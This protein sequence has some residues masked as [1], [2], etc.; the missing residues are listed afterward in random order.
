MLRRKNLTTDE[1]AQQLNSKTP[2]L[3]SLLRQQQPILQHNHWFDSLVE[4]DISRNKLTSL[5]TE[6]TSLS[7]L[8]TLNASSNLLTH[9]PPELY[10]LIHLQVLNLSQNQLHTIPDQLP[11]QLPYLVTLSVAGNSIDYLTPNVNRWIYLRHLQLGSVFGGNLLTQLPETICDMPCLEELELSF[12]QLRFLPDSM[13][14]P[15]LVNLNISR[16]Q[17]DSL[18]TSIGQC[19]ALKTLNVSKNHLTSLPATLVDLDSLELLDISENLLCIIPADILERMKMTLLITG[20]PL[21]RPGH[22]DASHASDD[23]Y[24][25][26]LKRMTTCALPMMS[27]S[28]GSPSSIN[29]QCGPQGNGCLSVAHTSP[30]IRST[31]SSH[32]IALAPTP[33]HTV[34]STPPPTSSSSLDNHHV[35]SRD[36]DTILD[37][38]LSILAQ[39]LNVQGSRSRKDQQ[40][41]TTP[42]DM[43]EDTTSTTSSDINQPMTPSLSTSSSSSTAH[44]TITPGT[45]IQDD[46][47]SRS[48]LMEAAEAVPYDED[49]VEAAI[50]DSTIPT[51]TNMLHSLRELATRVILQSDHVKV[52]FHL[53]PPHLAHDLS[54]RHQRRRC[55]KCQL[56]FVNEWLTSVQVKSYGGHPAVV[57]RVKFCSTKCWQLYLH[58]RNNSSVVCVH[59]PDTQPILR[60]SDE[61]EENDWLETAM[62]A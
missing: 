60:H 54:S 33:I 32:T 39:Q 5:P 44:T 23:A 47:F 27:S 52:P 3:A 40:Q 19:Q 14:I 58:S 43:Q 16:N 48:L 41:P 50:V 62:Q 56:P 51:A 17:L 34:P 26:M 1:L 46:R 7:H 25:Q 53:L 2:P 10:H 38:E 45:P 30:Q 49:E 57:H 42:N 12:N 11:L 29:H 35:D 31:P 8:R 9:L 21:T 15:S 6:I 55:A 24:T 4:L 22:C 28:S 20:N 13:V 18:P 37:R 36:D 59:Q 61:Q